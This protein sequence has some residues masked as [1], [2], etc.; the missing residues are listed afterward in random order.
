LRLED[1]G[2]R[3]GT[4][5]RGGPAHRPTDVAG[6]TTLSGETAVFVVVAAVALIVVLCGF[7]LSWRAT[8]LDRLHRRVDTSRAA[9]EAA[10]ARRGVAV[11]ALADSKGCDPAAS[12][13]L[14]DAV[15]ATHRAGADE[16]QL[17]ESALS[18]LLRKT[19]EDEERPFLRSE[20]RRVGKEGV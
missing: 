7:Y 18:G 19:L 4:R 17:A 10:L 11:L 8:R 5:V 20:E 1:R 12:R 16:C 6:W 15:E 9:L 3:R 14:V 13:A 2:G